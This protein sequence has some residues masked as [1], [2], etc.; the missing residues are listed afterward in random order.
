MSSYA[1]FAI[2][3]LICFF[4]FCCVTP[5]G[6]QKKE[7]QAAEDLIK[8]GDDKKLVQAQQSM[9]TL[10]A[11]SANKR[12]K[13][14][15]DMLF[16]SYAEQ[17]AHGNEKL[18]LKQKYDTVQLFNLAQNMFIVA[19]QLDS[20]EMLPD[21]K[22][23]VKAE[24]RKEHAEILATIRPN[25][26]NGGLYFIRKQQYDKA[27]SILNTYIDCTKQP[28][29]RNKCYNTLDPKLPSAAYWAVY[30]AYKL[31][32]TKAALHHVY[33][34]LKDK[35]HYEYMLQYL[36]EIY[37]LEKDTARYVSTLDDGFKNFTGNPF[38]Y[39]RL[40]DWYVN[41]GDYKKAMSY[42]DSLLAVKPKSVLGRFTKSTIL[43]NTERYSECIPICDSLIAEND[44]FPD[45]YINAGLAYFNMAVKL[46]KNIQH[47]RTNKQRILQYYTKA[48][49]YLEK[50]RKMR[51]ERKDQWALP[52]YTIYLNMNKGKEFDEIDKI[53]RS[54]P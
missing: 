40:I 23:R 2:V 21:R 53:M 7:I 33:W 11:D 12:N 6:A 35:Q 18:Y 30:C 54:Q 28:M 15:W 19:E 31:K 24:Y 3:F 14:I 1:R 41:A 5:A 17:Y 4:S 48:L 51:P 8:S 42:T 50:Y 39:T 49:P 22:G 26:Y 36:A 27:Y 44:S 16:R 43:L 45:A 37:K 25:L 29:F 13:K 46:D 52:L 20:I 47:L 10:L 38:F 32:D 34:G 9:Q